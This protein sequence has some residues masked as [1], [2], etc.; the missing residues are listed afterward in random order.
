[1]KSPDARLSALEQGMVRLEASVTS[2]AE[3]VR[4]F[5][6]DSRSANRDRDANYD[7]LAQAVFAGQKTDWGRVLTSLSVLIAFI[8]LAGTVVWYGVSVQFDRHTDRYEHLASQVSALE[9]SHRK[10]SVEAAVGIAVLAERLSW[11]RAVSGAPSPL[12][13]SLP[14]SPFPKAGAP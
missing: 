2:L 4:S 13:S 7:R 9:A 5:V 1:M 12:T 6:T 11:V 8:G 3:T 10:D 14:S